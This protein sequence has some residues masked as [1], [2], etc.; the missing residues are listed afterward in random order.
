VNSS[1]ST[2]NTNL[3][4]KSFLSPTKE[5]GR[6]LPYMTQLLIGGMGILFLKLAYHFFW[7]G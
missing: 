2:P 7:H 4:K 3:E 6:F 5:N 1:L